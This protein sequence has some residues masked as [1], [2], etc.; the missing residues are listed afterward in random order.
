M[1]RTLVA[2]GLSLVMAVT[3]YS[4][5]V[6][7]VDGPV[8]RTT[9]GR[10]RGT[11][12]GKVREFQG[13]PYAAAPT[14]AL[15][16]TAPRPPA[17]WA[18]IRDARH[19]GASCPQPA[20]AGPGAPKM[21]E[22]CLFLN[23]TAPRQA[24]KLPVLVWIHGGGF[25]GGTGSEYGTTRTATVANM[26][27]VTINYRL[28]V[29]GTFPHPRLGR[30]G[31]FGIQDQQAALRWVRREA[32]AFGG[33]SR[34]VTIAGESAGG[35]SVCSQLASPSAVGLFRRAIIA[36]GS[37]AMTHPRNAFA[38]GSGT[39]GTWQPAREISP[40]VADVGAQIGCP[41]SPR[42][43]RCLRGKSTSEVMRRN[44]P[45]FQ[46]V[47]HGTDVL[48]VEP[49]A[50]LTRGTSIRVPVMQGNTRDEH[51]RTIVNGYS[52][53][54]ID[55][56]RYREILADSFGAER[57]RQAATSYPLASFKSP[58]AALNRVYT[59]NDWICPSMFSSR[60]Y[61]RFRPTYGFVFDDP[62]APILDGGGPLPAG[63]TPATPHGAD[64]PFT[65]DWPTATPAQR[66]LSDT[67]LGYW[68]RFARTGD[69][70]G[71]GLPPWRAITDIPQAQLLRPD[72]IR[73]ID[74]N[75]A[76]HCD[77]WSPA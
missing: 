4:V 14:G 69:P 39:I 52:G 54:R 36:S 44:G 7:D 29:F 61:A 23:V 22:D 51:V 58:L 47:V 26:V 19:P 9:A 32:A 57:G 74:V 3:G 50:A 17:R 48:P 25:I 18:G 37:C 75:K 72:S 12:D 8:V 73:T 63:V 24:R 62:N 15:R 53:Q 71:R 66:R 49:A 31:A 16:W 13:I 21:S 43:L 35:M 64:V 38:P 11:D 33:D 20:E 28:G 76:H 5:D 27:V 65:F 46:Y 68:A 34:E 56:R 41:D 42:V 30:A 67:M 70:N 10:I 55:H 40:A 6:G 45:L 1:V 77:F 59:D 60:R 2:G